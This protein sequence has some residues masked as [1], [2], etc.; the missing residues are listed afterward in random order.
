MSSFT[1]IH[2]A[3]IFEF[4]LSSL[5]Q[6]ELDTSSSVILLEHHSLV[7]GARS[8]NSCSSHI[9]IFD[10]NS[11]P[12]ITRHLN[13]RGT[14]P[15]PTG[16]LEKVIILPLRRQ[17]RRP[18][19]RRHLH[20]SRPLIPIDHLRTK[21]I[22]GHTRLEIDLQRRRDAAVDIVPRHVNDSQTLVRELDEAILEEIE[23]IGAAV[24]TF[25][26]DHGGD[27]FSRVCHGDA[28][29]AVG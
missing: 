5:C 23:V 27:G 26:D 29:A 13:P 12:A 18:G 19:I 21:P 22:L 1:I 10:S 16:N 7:I 4:R 6:W 8:R 3:W 11:R 24:G 9:D 15:R 28:S 17:P 14:R 25:V 20:A 2:L